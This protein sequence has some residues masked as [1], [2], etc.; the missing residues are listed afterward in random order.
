MRLQNLIRAG[1][2]PSMS[3]HKAVRFRKQSQRE[4]DM[5][6]NQN[7]YQCD[8]TDQLLGTSFHSKF[9]ADVKFGVKQSHFPKTLHT[10]PPYLITVPAFTQSRGEQIQ[11]NDQQNN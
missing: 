1:T 5:Q 9:T 4:G 10:I 6:S 7:S 2:A 11:G 3:A 8:G